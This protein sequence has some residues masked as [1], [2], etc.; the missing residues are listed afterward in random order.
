MTNPLV[1]ALAFVAAVIIPGG[2][3]VYFAWRAISLKGQPNHT[4][5][6]EGFEDI[7]EAEL[8]LPDA[9]LAAFLE[10]FPK[11]SKDSLRA[12]SRADRIRVARTRP[13]KKNQ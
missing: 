13:K 6:K 7:S 3:L 12:K 2:L 8:P 10:A 4:E 11:Y 9:A 1:H 5:Q